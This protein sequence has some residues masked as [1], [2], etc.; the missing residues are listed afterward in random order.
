MN[1]P[2]FSAELTT[3]CARGEGKIFVEI[4]VSLVEMGGVCRIVGPVTDRR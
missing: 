2:L 4:G 3:T 1:S